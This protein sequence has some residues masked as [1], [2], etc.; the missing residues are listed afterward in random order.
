MEDRI[1]PYV[2]FWTWEL[3]SWPKNARLL[4]LW[5]PAVLLL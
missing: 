1:T 3:F 4:L 5:A 2:I